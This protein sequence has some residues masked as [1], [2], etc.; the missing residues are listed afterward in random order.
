[1]RRQSL[2]SGNLTVNHWQNG[3]GVGGDGAKPIYLI[4]TFSFLHLHL[5]A[6]VV[7]AP[8]C[9]GPED[10]LVNACWVGGTGGT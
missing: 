3:V 5:S 4:L 2:G 10:I 8:E 6:A 9:K 1:M 7:L